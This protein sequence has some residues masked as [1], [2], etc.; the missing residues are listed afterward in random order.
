[1]A[2]L[3]VFKEKRSSRNRNHDRPEP[4]IPI[5]WNPRVHWRRFWE[6]GLSL[7]ALKKGFPDY[8][9]FGIMRL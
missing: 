3:R 8:L 7:P 9:F 5:P 2:E 1:M 6:K 4:P